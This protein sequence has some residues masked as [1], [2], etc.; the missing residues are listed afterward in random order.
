MSKK[1]ELRLELTEEEAVLLLGCVKERAMEADAFRGLIPHVA[2][3]RLPTKWD[4]LAKTVAR[5]LLEAYKSTSGQ[6]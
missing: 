4:V 5:A 1:I 6:A 3:S 2:N